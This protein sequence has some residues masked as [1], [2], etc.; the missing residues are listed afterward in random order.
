M[1]E[2][3]VV[4]GVLEALKSR[5]AWTGD[6]GVR[7]GVLRNEVGVIWLW[8]YLGGVYGD[9]RLSGG[10]GGGG[11]G[12]LYPSPNLCLALGS[13]VGVVVLRWR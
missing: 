3:E 8:R 11:G 4:L 13:R 1:V 6:T 2:E 7:Y 10:G 5:E 12:V 9:D